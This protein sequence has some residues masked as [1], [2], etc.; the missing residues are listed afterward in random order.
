MKLFVAYGRRDKDAVSTLVGQCERAGHQVWVDQDLHGDEAW[1]NAILAAIRE[2][3]V[4]VL[5]L[6]EDSMESDSCHAQVAYARL[7]VLPI[8]WGYFR[9]MSKPDRAN[10]D[11][12]SVEG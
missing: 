12:A 9:S 8:L 7:L 5:V 10:A 4:F 2:C 3:D 6:S 11:R 1:W